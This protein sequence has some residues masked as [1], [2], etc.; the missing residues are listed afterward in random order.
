MTEGSLGLVAFIG[1]GQ[2]REAPSEKGTRFSKFQVRVGVSQVEVHER[3]R[4]SV[5]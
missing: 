4:K 5:I 1:W 3:V 2:D